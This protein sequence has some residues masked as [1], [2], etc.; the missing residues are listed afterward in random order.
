M[1]GT[2]LPSLVASDRSRSGRAVNMGRPIRIPKPLDGLA[3]IMMR[4]E[5]VRAGR[6]HEI[7]ISVPLRPEDHP[8]RMVGKNR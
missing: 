3:T 8:K 4:D 1:I 5:P 6:R 7:S 2:R